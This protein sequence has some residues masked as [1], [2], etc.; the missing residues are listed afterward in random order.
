MVRV[1]VWIVVPPTCKLIVSWPLVPRARTTIVLEPPLVLPVDEDEL[2]LE[3][4]ELEELL[5]DEEPLVVLP[6][7]TV[8]LD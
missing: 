5:D 7:L 2:E 3:L 6:T 4:E 1:Q 8:M